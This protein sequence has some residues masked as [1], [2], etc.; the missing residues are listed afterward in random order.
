VLKPSIGPRF[1]NSPNFS[2]K[3]YYNYKSIDLIKKK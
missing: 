2:G 1:V 3:F